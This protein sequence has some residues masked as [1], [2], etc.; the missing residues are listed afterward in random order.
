MACGDKFRTLYLV[1]DR[2]Q[3]EAAPCFGSCGEI[4]DYPPWNRNVTR[5]AASLSSAESK[6]LD[7]G[8][9]MPADLADQLANWRALAERYPGD[10]LD[11]MASGTPP[12]PNAE[13]GMRAVVEGMIQL[14]RDGACLLEQIIDRT[15]ALGGTPPT[16]PTTPPWKAPPPGL[17]FWTLAIIGV[18]LFL[19]N[20]AGVFGSGDDDDG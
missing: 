4:E 17:D 9:A 3:T 18:G 5:L 19:A 2:G 15:I 14:L 1:T 7:T 12:P 16:M 6:L 13:L 10:L 8:N 20:R 11:A